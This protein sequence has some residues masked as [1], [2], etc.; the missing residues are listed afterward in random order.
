MMTKSSFYRYSTGLFNDNP[1]VFFI[2][3]TL[4]EQESL[5]AWPQEAYHPPRSCSVLH[6]VPMGWG[7]PP[8]SSDDGYPIQ[9]PI[10]RNG[11]PP[12]GTG[13]DN[14]S[15]SWKI[16][17]PPVRKDWSTPPVRKDG[18]TPP[19]HQEGW[20]T[21]HREDGGT[22]PPVRKDGG[23]PSLKV[24]QTHTCENK[25]SCHLSDAGGNNYTGRI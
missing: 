11:L 13:W 3:I 4:S 17:V 5:L 8:S 23:T 7:V 20:G 10:R 16:G 19:P 21:H 24:R 6:L 18:D 14:N 9:S 22:A 15:P 1:E 2:C 25:T 12:V